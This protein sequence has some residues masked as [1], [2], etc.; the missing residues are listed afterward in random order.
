[1]HIVYLHQYFTPAD[2]VGSTR[3]YEKARRLVQAGH[4]V[5]LVTSTAFFPPSYRFDILV[6]DL[7]IDG[8]D[9]KVIRVA[10]S[11]RQ[12]YLRRILAF[13]HFAVLCA[14]VAMRIRNVDLVFATS[15]PLTIMIP[16]IV[17]KWRHA[18]PMV[19][20]VRDQWPKVPIT[21][22]ILRNPLAIV[23]AQWMERSAY[24]QSSHIVALSPCTRDGIVAMGISQNDISVIPNCSDT[25]LF[26]VDR[27][28]GNTF[29]D[30]HPHLR[31]KK[32]VAY[33]GTL[34]FANGVDYIVQLAAQMQNRD[35]K[36]CFVVAGDGAKRD[37]LTAL[38]DKLG[39]L[40]K[41]FWMLA[42]L[43]KNKVPPFLSAAT[44]VCSTF[45]LDAAPWPN[46]ANK[47]FDGLAAGKPVVINYQGWQKDVLDRSGAGIALPPDDLD[48]AAN[49]LKCFLDDNVAI[50][51]SSIA[52][53]LL[54]DTHYNRA[55][56]AEK[57]RR[58]LEE[59]AAPQNHR[60]F[61]RTP[62]ERP[63][64]EPPLAQPHIKRALPSQQKQ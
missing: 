2:G 32:I 26:R 48:K 23:V 3:S 37:E 21:L 17:A 57:L 51:K 54:A 49:K 9:L 10:Y 63:M 31:S 39:V 55:H 4:Q 34:G 52:S 35:S 14:F 5:T 7:A 41:N 46:S 27:A 40:G 25:D 33:A 18:V 30:Q 38:A 56:L 45:I 61:S 19:F 60:N 24:R 16:G 13:F 42:P 64:Y 36:I 44:A 6:N 47:F 15:T 29:L 1:M 8:I 62:N 58:V 22:G 43:P 53:S 20:E 12:S 59:A 50:T 28:V 11:N